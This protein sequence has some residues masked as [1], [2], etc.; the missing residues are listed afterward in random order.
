[1]GNKSDG[2]LSLVE[3]DVRF[4]FSFNLYFLVCGELDNR[5]LVYFIL[6]Y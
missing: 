1:M 3:S 5:C 4:F 2:G 6:N